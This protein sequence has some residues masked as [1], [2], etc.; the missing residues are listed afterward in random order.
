MFQEN[1]L[2]NHAV[3]TRS[4]KTSLLPLSNSKTLNYSSRARPRSYTDDF[5]SSP[6]L[7]NE[8]D[9]RPF[10]NIC[11]LEADESDSETEDESFALKESAVSEQAQISIYRRECETARRVKLFSHAKDRIG[12][13]I[14]QISHLRNQ[15]EK[16]KDVK[17]RI[18][19]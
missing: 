2:F 15:L 17:I 4:L 14:L 9:P 7:S 19:K 18:L 16:L 13:S 6:N 3:H 12:E 5:S 10:M 8:W 11:F 1:V